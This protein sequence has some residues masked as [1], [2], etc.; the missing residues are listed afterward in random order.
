MPPDICGLTLDRA[1]FRAGVSFRNNLQ[2]QLQGFRGT[3]LAR[4]ASW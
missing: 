3:F 4:G 2:R 1:E